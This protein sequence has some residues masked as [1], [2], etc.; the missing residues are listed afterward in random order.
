MGLA[1]AALVEG[2][3]YGVP[4]EVGEVG[5]GNTEES[6]H[7]ADIEA[8]GTLFGKDLGDG[9]EGGGV[10]FLLMWGSV[11]NCSSIGGSIF[12]TGSESVC[13][14]RDGSGGG[15]EVV[16]GTGAYFSAAAAANVG[17]F[18]V[19]RRLTWTWSLVLTLFRA[20]RLA[21]C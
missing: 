19:V 14:L 12:R 1:S 5:G 17:G 3:N 13:E 15:E 11:C 10:D 8:G 2:A 18:G 9:I 21:D 6:A 16:G 4:V 7:H 20:R